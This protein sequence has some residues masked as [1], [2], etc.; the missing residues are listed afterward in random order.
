MLDISRGVQ[1]LHSFGI[2][3]RDMKSLNL[4]VTQAY[5]IKVSDFGSARVSHEQGF[6][7]GCCGTYQWM[8]PEVI[9]SQRYSHSA[10]IYSFAIV[11]WEIVHVAPPFANANPTQVAMQ[12]IHQHLRPTLDRKVPP[13]LRQLMQQSWHPDP[14]RRPCA[15]QVTS[16]LE[17]LVQNARQF[18]K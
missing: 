8:A 14:T 12:V 17:K 10:D 7:T 5:R 18:K 15:E 2:I 16:T 4:L 1:F 6:N 3:H 9:A 13:P 11:M